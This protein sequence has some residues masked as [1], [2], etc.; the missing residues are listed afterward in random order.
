[1]LTDK[2]QCSMMMCHARYAYDD[3][4]TI[5]ISTYTYDVL[6]VVQATYARCLS[7][8]GSAK[9]C[10]VIAMSSYDSRMIIL[11]TNLTLSAEATFVRAKKAREGTDKTHTIASYS[12]G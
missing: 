12:K 8:C 3:N 5:C 6:I 4:V 1:M 11:C 2:V 10:G 7:K 9:A